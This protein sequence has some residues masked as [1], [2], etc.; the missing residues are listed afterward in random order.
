M[1][2]TLITVH[3]K[4][5]QMMAYIIKLKLRKFQQPTV[6]RFSTARK[7]V[8]GGGGGGGLHL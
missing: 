1:V 4:L 2:T 8:G 7:P 5:L 6:N 3:C